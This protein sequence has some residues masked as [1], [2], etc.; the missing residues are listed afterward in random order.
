MSPVLLFIFCLLLHKLHSLVCSTVRL[1]VFA[2]ALEIEILLSPEIFLVFFYTT[3]F[4]EVFL[5]LNKP[6]T[7]VRGIIIVLLL[8]LDLGLEQLISLK[9]G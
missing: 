6:K 1:K 7:F 5:F 2:I 9:L 8:V 4:K 3:R